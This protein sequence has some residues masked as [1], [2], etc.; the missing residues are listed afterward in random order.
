MFV[1]RGDALLV[2]PAVF[3]HEIL[4]IARFLAAHSITP[5]LIA[6]THSHWDH[7]LGPEQF[8][9]IKTIAHANYVSCIRDHSREIVED[10]EQW[11]RD[12]NVHRRMKFEIPLPDMTFQDR[13]EVRIGDLSLQ[14]L[15]VPGHARDQLAVYEPDSGTLWASDILSDVEIPFVSD[16]L[17]AYEQTLNYLSTLDVRVIIPGHGHATSESNEIEKR[18]REDADYLSILRARITRAVEN[19]RSLEETVTACRDIAYRQP[20]LNQEPHRN[21]VESVYLELG[22]DTDPE[23]VGWSKR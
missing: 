13:M 22:G 12:E 11:C 23:N 19:G 18:F 7:L 15:H 16:S 5:Q 2:D 8:P 3:P 20:T 21:N 1:S 17:H 10:I 6:L 9:G 14:F 4:D